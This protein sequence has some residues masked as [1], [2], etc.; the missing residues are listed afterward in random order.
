M[1]GWDD[2]ADAL[3]GAG[4]DDAGLDAAALLRAFI[5]RDV[6]AVP[7]IYN[8]YSQDG[9]PLIVA[10]TAVAATLL[11]DRYDG[12]REA[13]LGALN[14]LTAASLAAANTG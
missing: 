7:V 8:A 5:T 4:Y 6:V 13:V 12:D 3:H 14:E 1:T 10:L 9:T 2:V 11:G